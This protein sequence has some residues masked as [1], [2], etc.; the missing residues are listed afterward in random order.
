MTNEAKM[1]VKQLYVRPKK[2]FITFTVSVGIFLSTMIL[3]LTV[4]RSSSFDDPVFGPFF[5]LCMISLYP[6]VV[7][8][9]MYAVRKNP[10]KA[11]VKTL[12]RT[13][14]LG[15]VS[16]I[17]SGDYNSD[18]K[19][20]FSKN[21]LYVPKKNIVIAYDD[22][23]WVYGKR[24]SVYGLTISSLYVF[25]L[26]DGSYFEINVSDETVKDFLYRRPNILVGYTS[27]NNI[28]HKEK[29]K[30]FKKQLKGRV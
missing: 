17:T 21:L 12:E 8:S 9:I 6:A 22:I 24:N 15:L 19:V 26:I 28:L 7:T 27:E 3:L 25:C 30:E 5:I 20:A 10:L 4:F 29:V 2:L 14:K 13:G 23:V 1:A 18:G 11:S 16:E